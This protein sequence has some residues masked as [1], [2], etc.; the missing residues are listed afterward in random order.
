MVDD[1]FRRRSTGSGGPEDDRPAAKPRVRRGTLSFGELPPV[2]E[3]PETPSGPQT[4]LRGIGAK[5]DVVPSAPRSTPRA[6][7]FDTRSRPYRPVKHE[8][9]VDAMVPHISWMTDEQRGDFK[10]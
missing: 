7:A 2:Q 1:P 3:R 5:S 6:P 10:S 4:T 9:I 8:G